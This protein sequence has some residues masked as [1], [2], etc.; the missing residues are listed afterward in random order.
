MVRSKFGRDSIVV[1]RS[2]TKITTPH[3]GKQT[4]NTPTKKTNN[5]KYVEHVRDLINSIKSI[6]KEDKKEILLL[7]DQYKQDFPELC[8]CYANDDLYQDQPQNIWLA[9]LF[10]L[11]LTI[12]DSLKTLD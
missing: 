12:R 2:N 9:S 7:L 8:Q 3:K 6:N 1:S 11:V 4:L 10:P 5:V